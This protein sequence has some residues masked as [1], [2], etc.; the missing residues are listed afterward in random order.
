MKDKYDF[1]KLKITPV[2]EKP[3]DGTKTHWIINDEIGLGSFNCSFPEIEKIKIYK[4]LNFF[5]FRNI[6]QLFLVQIF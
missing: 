4:V 3:Y 2:L 1:E 6:T 5:L